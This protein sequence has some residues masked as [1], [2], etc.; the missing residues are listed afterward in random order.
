[1]NID[2]LPP[3]PVVDGEEIRHIPN[4]PG[5]GAC[6]DGTIWGC[7][8]PGGG[9]ADEWSE[10]SVGPGGV[11]RNYLQFWPMRAGRKVTVK[12]HRAV[13][14]AFIGKIPRGKAVRHWDDNPMNNRPENL[15]VGT[16]KDNTED[17]RRNGIRVGREKG[18]R[19][20]DPSVVSKMKQMHRDESLSVR[21][22]AIR[23]G[24]PY[25]TA[26]DA[27]ARRNRGESK[28]PGS[29]ASA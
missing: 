9:I 26:Y 8:R 20:L 4:L 10:R 29:R 14:E 3:F 11:K 2:E 13:Y 16:W 12:V 6:S 24:I 27:I 17:A 21:Q 15:R 28:G 25:G 19:N 5:Y 22:I 7:L 18:S 23:F 1:M